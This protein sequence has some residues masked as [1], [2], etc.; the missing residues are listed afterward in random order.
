[1]TLGGCIPTNMGGGNLS[2]SYMH[3]WSQIAEVVRQLR[4]EAGVQQIA[5]LR[6]SLS[7]LT[8]TDQTHPIIF[9]GTVG[10]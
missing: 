9:E 7:A 6:Y 8:Q 2:G 4:H 1:M 3:G 10:R 5:G